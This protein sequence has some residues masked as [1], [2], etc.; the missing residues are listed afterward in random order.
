MIR[1]F[2][3]ENFRGIKH[4]EMREIKPLT[5]VVG[6][7]NVGKSSFLEAV[8]LFY[9]HYAPDVFAKLSNLRGGYIEPN[10][11]LWEPV[12]NHMDTDKKM[13]LAM[14]TMDGKKAQLIIEKD[15][16]YIMS[17]AQPPNPI[18]NNLLNNSVKS[19]YSL[20]YEYQHEDYHELGHFSAGDTGIMVNVTTTL[21]QNEREKMPWTLFV[22][23]I[24]PRMTLDVIEWIGNLEI[25]ERKES[26]IEVLRMI[27]P[28]IRDIFSATQN[29]VTQL[30]IK[31]GDGIMPLKYAGDGVVRLI[32]IMAAMMSNRDSLLL[33]D[34]I[35]NGFHYSVYAKIWESLAK[36]SKEY[37]CQIIATTHNYEH[38]DEGIEGVRTAGREEEFSLHRLERT[39]DGLKDNYFSSKNL[40]TALEMNL[41]VR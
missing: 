40:K 36:V 29:G 20:K 15:M 24:A 16:D 39:K 4:L 7:N 35:E 27:A 19:D 18:V 41:E 32:Y 22:N 14:E 6:K 5:L 28:D 31:N 2:S 33:I 10:N 30:Y 17:P 34:E 25:S 1:G 38:I 9:D 11:R 21:P 13:R 23:S 12:F 3:V 8:F 26:A 37:N